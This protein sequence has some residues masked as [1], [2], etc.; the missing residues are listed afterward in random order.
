MSTPLRTALSH[1]VGWAAE[2]RIP[3]P[4]RAP[5]YAG[6]ARLTGADLAEARLALDHYPSLGAF[7]VREL[8]AG[9]RPI[10]AAPDALVSPVDG[11]VQHVGPIDDGRTLQAKGRSYPVAELLGPAA[12]GLDLA[13][14]SAWTL[15]LSPRDYHRIHAPEACRIEGAWWIQGARWS[16]APA[17]L[18]RRLVLPVNERVALRLATPHGPL[19]FVLVGATNVGRMRVVGVEPGHAGALDPPP[20]LAR[21][22]ELGRFEMGST[23]VIVAPGDVAR[24]A[25]G[26]AHGA[27]VRLGRPIGRFT[28]SAG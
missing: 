23:V 9:A 1:V 14:G 24:P 2:R 28:R 11:A 4:L 25:P 20:A 17:L 16:V 5:L 8:A 18:D 27:P 10:D 15:Y 6:F 12:D 21:G 22:Q 13:R 7:F 26:L 3:R 19:G